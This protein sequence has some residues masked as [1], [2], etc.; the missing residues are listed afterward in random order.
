RSSLSGHRGAR[1]GGVA[2]WMTGAGDARDR[3]DGGTEGGMSPRAA[4]KDAEP[5]GGIP[6][7]LPGMGGRALYAHLAPGRPRAPPP[8]NP[9][10][11]RFDGTYLWLTATTVRQKNRNWQV[12]PA[13]ALS[14][15]DPDRPYRYLEIRG[16]VERVVPD[17]QAAEFLRLADR[18]GMEQPG[19]PPDAADRLAA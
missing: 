18:Y 2:G 16:R 1:G 7:A 15:I 11:V 19:P 13:V 6:G 12:Q 10:W 9:T 8:G 17:P 14:I 5:A 3:R 4:G